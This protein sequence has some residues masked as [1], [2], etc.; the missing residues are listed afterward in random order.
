MKSAAL[1]RAFLLI[2]RRSTPVAL[3]ACSGSISVSP[4][5]GN[6]A[7]AGT[8]EASPADRNDGMAQAPEASPAGDI[9]APVEAADLDAL[10]LDASV[11]NACDANS[12]CSPCALPCDNAHPSAPACQGN[13]VALE[14]GA[15]DA[16][17]GSWDGGW[18]LWSLAASALSDAG[19]PVCGY[20][21]FGCSFPS[22]RPFED[23]GNW[24]AQC[25]VDCSGR[26]PAHLDPVR[27]S[28]GTPLGAYF[29]RMAHLE[30]ASVFAFRHLRR[31]LV[32]HR[33]PR[34][35]VRAAERAARDELRHARLTAALARRFGGTLLPAV[36]G[37]MEIGTLETLAIEN[38]VEGCTREAFGAL[39]ATWQARTAEDPLVRAALARIARDETRHA[40]FAF[41]VRA[42]LNGRLGA[43]ARAR[44]REA[45][46]EALRELSSRKGEAPDGLR[47]QLGLPSA[48]HA[49][50]L[51]QEL[52]RLAA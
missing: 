12:P 37:P 19:P 13:V 23:G 46:A 3:V 2:L 47:R 52:G 31:Q 14:A 11:A 16:I 30:A 33:A 21:S 1:T 42:W 9:V 5:G 6:D 36:V 28:P 32:A 50:V 8:P 38:A 18:I 41:E 34:R 15:I 10:G 7:T 40:A 24:F 26:R 22:C 39:V 48:S 20:S 27:E 25:V 51:A 45:A 35:L 44:V 4:A 17:A 43:A 29:A 49:R